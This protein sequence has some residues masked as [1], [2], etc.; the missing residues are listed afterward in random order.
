MLRAEKYGQSALA[1]L[2]GPAAT[3]IDALIT[4]IGSG[5]PKRISTA[6][7]NLTPIGALP[8]VSRPEI[9]LTEFV[10]EVLE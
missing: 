8:K 9:G 1:G 10:E 3:K 5:S 6:L 2:A 4:A 7:G